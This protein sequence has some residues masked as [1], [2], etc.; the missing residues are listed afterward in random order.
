LIFVQ[1]ASAVQSKGVVK[2]NTSGYLCLQLLPN[3]SIMLNNI[4]KQKMN[5][6]WVFG[7]IIL[8]VLPW[9]E[10]L[11]YEGN[12]FLTILS[13]V[14]R[15]GLA[16]GLFILPGI[17]LFIL[18]PPQKNAYSRSL[19]LI[20]IGFTFSTLLIGIVGLIGRGLG[21]SFESVRFIFALIGLV[22]ILA[23]MNIYPGF[24][25]QKFNL[26]DKIRNSIQNLPLLGALLIG[27]LMLFNTSLFFIDD[28]TYLA[29][30][31]NWQES[32]N[33][34]F[35]EVI[36]GTGVTEAS[37]F[38]FA[39]YP[40]GQALLSE[41]S[42]I[43][44][45]L[46]LGN[47]L[48][49]F[50][51]SIAILSMYYF[52]RKLNLS[53]RAASLSV[54]AHIVLFCWLVG[55]DQNRTG[56]WFFQSMAEDKVS[57]VFIL[58]PVLFSFL[59]DYIKK[60]VSRNF[61]LLFLAGFSVSLTHPVILFFCE[62]IVLGLAA[63]AYLT[64]KFSWK[65]LTKIILV[66]VIW[67]SPFIA[68]RFSGHPSIANV[69]YNA[70]KAEGTLTIERHIDVREDGLYNIPI[71][72]LKFVD[73]QIGS[74][75]NSGYQIY[76]FLPIVIM[77][78]AGL[79]GLL[80]IKRG[81]VYAYL[82]VSTALIVLTMIPYT[83]W[84]LGY[85][86]SARMLIRGSWFAPLGIGLV[87]IVKTAVEFIDE[88]IKKK[89][90]VRWEKITR[91][92]YARIYL[93]GFAFMLMLGLGS[94]TMVEVIRSIPS[95]AST[96]SFYRQLGQVGAYISNNNLEKVAV[97][98]LNATDNYLP[99]VSASAKPISFRDEAK[100]EVE[101]FLTLQEHDERHRDSGI[102]Q[103]LEAG[104][105][106]DKRRALI[107]KYEIRYILADTQQV[108]TYLKIMNQNN[109]LLEIVYQTRDFTLFQ[110]NGF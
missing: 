2:V 66:M 44:G 15:L 18:L 16:V 98:T 35:N 99:G 74:D 109:P 76:R 100:F 11:T 69:P 55:Q 89:R 46:L 5:F 79:I 14:L 22:E 62:C 105:P 88:I 77:L 38:W 27:N 3:L 30:L 65:N 40:M 84:L 37:R 39:L 25:Q 56:M 81:Y 1:S 75:Q 60:P 26:L 29:Y 101:Y 59:I 53:K 68:I 45:I 108:E 85:I 78:G 33:L 10:W 47:Y 83:A 7:W 93:W 72:V 21:F 8:W 67:M 4:K 63:I 23:I 6:F 86:A 103:S 36:Y 24:F 32:T 31:T 43:P 28:W 49:F 82:F 17:F 51:V 50:L 107:N 95:L 54:F 52:A 42:N 61:Q 64:Q 57:A 73:V 13:D 34:S 41:L 80:N 20:P 12:L 92:T 87:M 71:D 9:G 106:L 70:N 104:I 110:V 58:A 91:G 97:I 48:E 90:F 19:A 94:P 96:L 102:I